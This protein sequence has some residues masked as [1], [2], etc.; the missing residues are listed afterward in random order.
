MA[1]RPEPTLRAQW[2]GQQLRRYREA[3]G[4]TLKEA[5][6]Y[7]NRDS[8]TVSR[9][10]AG[11]YPPRDNDVQE[12]LTLYGV[13]SEPIRS[14]LRKLSMEVWQK[15]WWEGYAKDVDPSIVDYAWL[16]AR[17]AEI[18]SFNPIVVPGLLQT[19]AYAEA[20]MRAV[21]PDVPDE[22]VDRW[23]EVRMLRQQTLS[24]PRPTQFT[25]ILDESVLRRPVGG[26]RVM[27]EQLEHLA[28][29]AL[30]PNIHI[31]VLPERLG[32]HAAPD[33][34]FKLFNMPEPYP[35]LACIET[36]AGVIYVEDDGI[37]R[38]VAA[39][40]RLE[41]AT[42]DREESIAELQKWSR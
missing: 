7:L 38:F 39:F 29:V 33:G 42:L 21:D 10:E 1:A 37:K 11:L 26:H 40:D 13:S 31:R 20:V 35:N 30:R 3:A 17:A 5:A 34:S 24:L 27:T 9:F 28:E 22:Q 12:L 2:L 41:Q 32:A 4:L 8:S 36:P 19:P 15:G 25:A 6:A 18:K 23:L 16:E 14:S